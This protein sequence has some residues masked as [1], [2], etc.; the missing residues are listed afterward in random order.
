MAGNIFIGNVVED[1]VGHGVTAGGYGHL[2]TKT[3]LDNVF[4]A[5]AAAGNGGGAFNPMHGAASGNFW[6]ANSAAHGGEPEW[7]AL[8]TSNANVSI[9]E[10]SSAPA[11]DDGR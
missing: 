4:L 11:P 9:F 1:N 3:S 2:P 7:N 10:P 5:N 8:P 6:I